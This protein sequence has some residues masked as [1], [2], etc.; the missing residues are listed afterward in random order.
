VKAALFSHGPWLEKYL[1]SY[2]FKYDISMYQHFYGSGISVGFVT[3]DPV[4]NMLHFVV[5]LV[6]DFGAFPELVNDFFM[7]FTGMLVMKLVFKAGP[8]IH[9]HRP[10]LYFDL[11][12]LFAV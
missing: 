4:I 2:G 10:D 7:A 9:G 1:Y 5:C 12:E 11:D 8:E 6:D 3:H